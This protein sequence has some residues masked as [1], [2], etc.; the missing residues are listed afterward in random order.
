MRARLCTA[1]VFF[2][3]STVACGGAELEFAD[4][5]PPLPR[6]GVEV[7]EYAGVPYD[8][9]AGGEIELRE[10]L[11]LGHE[12]NPEETFYQ[13]TGVVSDAQGNIFVLDRGDHRV[14]M[15]D[16]SGAYLRTLGQQGQGPGELASPT[17]LTVSREHL[18]LRADTR[19]LSVWTLTGEH[20][21]DVN[22]SESLLSMM[23]FDDGFVARSSHRPETE[24]GAEM[25][26]RTL[27]YAAY[28]PFGGQLREL[29]DLQEPPPV[30]L[31]I[32]SGGGF[33]TMSGGPIADWF[34]R[35]AVAL[36]GAFYLTTSSAYQLHA[37]GAQPW[38]LRV[39]WSREPVTRQH[40]DTVTE[41]YL[42]DGPFAEADLSGIE[43]PDHFSAISGI[44]LDGHGHL[45]VFP[46]HL[47]LHQPIAED[48]ERPDLPRPVDVYGADGELL[49][50]GLIDI[51]GWSSARGDFVYAT[52]TNEDTEETEVV[53]YRLA[54][55]F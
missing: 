23:G 50:N 22:L 32:G 35:A 26:S 2:L 4:W 47:P 28:D 14:Q 9:R 11:V 55:P 46:F 42:S 37:Y 52:R 8:E 5:I 44:E 18:T 54:E 40:I 29:A 38:S 6:E 21:R 20:L 41:R 3:F 49:F 12:T 34:A 53:R 10:D 30:T 43:W 33:I 16:P 51:A 25:P 15:F 45:Y 19:R 39:A 27:T 17:S 1:L 7:F 48:E 13:P 36:D 31:T 24:P